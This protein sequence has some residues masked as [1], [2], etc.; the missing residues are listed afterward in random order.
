MSRRFPGADERSHNPSAD[1]ARDHI[2]VQ[3]SAG[4]Y[5]SRILKLV[6]SRR[7]DRDVGESRVGQEPLVFLFFEGAGTVPF[8]ALGEPSTRPRT[9]AIAIGPEGGFSRDETTAARDAGFMLVDMGPRI[10]RTETAAL[11]ALALV[12][13]RW[14]DLGGR[15][16]R[17]D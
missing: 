8:A 6:N 11:V 7:L 4:Q 10:L 2:D 5:G 3:A 15:D 9:V 17:S 14:G 16:A 1:L 12:Q 13:A